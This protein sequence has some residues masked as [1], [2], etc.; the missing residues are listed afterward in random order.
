MQ[1]VW[2]SGTLV[3][4]MHLR[5]GGQAQRPQ[6]ML[7]RKV[8]AFVTRILSVMGLVD[9]PSDRPGFGTSDSGDSS[10]GNV[11][12]REGAWCAAVAGVRDRLRAVAQLPAPELKGAVM[13]LSDRSGF[14]LHMSHILEVAL[15]A[16]M[17]AEIARVYSSR[18][19]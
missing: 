14:P 10:S 9:A 13:E 16:D 12:A 6:P 15:P 18:S 7:L 2:C 19:S 4:S 17:P 5:A 3:S 11:T 8:T 1:A